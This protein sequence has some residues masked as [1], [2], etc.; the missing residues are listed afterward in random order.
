M[1]DRILPELSDPWGKSSVASYTFIQWRFSCFECFQIAMRD[2]FSASIIFKKS[3]WRLLLY[4]WN[5]CQTSPW[6]LELGGRRRTPSGG[7][8]STIGSAPNKVFET[9][10]IKYLGFTPS[11]G[12]SCFAQ[13]YDE[14]ADHHD[15][16]VLPWLGSFSQPE[17]PDDLQHFSIFTYITLHFLLLNGCLF[18]LITFSS[19]SIAI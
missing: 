19:S 7:I 8:A 10:R 4:P 9:L 15:A 17:L 13:P 1:I 6:R 5:A 18:V 14:W 12:R 2:K 16:E 3:F 11:I